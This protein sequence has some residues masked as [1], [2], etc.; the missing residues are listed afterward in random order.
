MLSKKSKSAL[1]VFSFVF[2]LAVVMLSVSVFASAAISAPQNVQAQLIHNEVHLSWS[3]VAN[4]T[5]YKIY[6]STDNTTFTYLNN[7]TARSFIVDLNGETAGTY[8]FKI[9]AVN[10]TDTN[11]TVISVKFYPPAA[12]QGLTAIVQAGKIKLS[13]NAV[14]EATGYYIY[15]GTEAGKESL[16]VS[17]LGTNYTDDSVVG[18]NTYYYYVTAYNATGESQASAEI[19][20]SI[21]SGGGT[22]VIKDVAFNTYLLAAGAILLIFA[23]PIYLFGAKSHKDVAGYASIAGVIMLLASWALEEAGYK[24]EILTIAGVALNSILVVLAVIF[25]I[26]GVGLI[27]LG[28]KDKKM[29]KHTDVGT[30]SLAFGIIAL[31]VSIVMSLIAG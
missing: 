27:L 23:L 22:T 2:I 20:V 25:I 3:E 11:A 6:E 31:V 13:W 24:T 4:A 8:Y 21:T 1:R 5:E 17:V 9:E 29:K 10:G 19:E 12:P 18:G 26:I 28:K 30:F 14:A 16:L 7:T 15:R